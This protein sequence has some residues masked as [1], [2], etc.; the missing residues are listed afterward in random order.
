MDALRKLLDNEKGLVAILLIA[1]ASVFV[2]VGRMS[3][4]DWK[5][6]A[7]WIFIPYAGATAMHES[8]VAFSNRPAAAAPTISATATTATETTTT[9]AK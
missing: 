5:T 7:T 2:V 6:F 1:A 8:A 9:E 4:E 3:V